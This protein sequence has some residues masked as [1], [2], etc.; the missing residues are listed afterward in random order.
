LGAIVYVGQIIGCQTSSY[1]L[2]RADEKKVL[3]TVLFF[4]ILCLYWFTLVDDFANLV[5]CRAFTGL[6]QESTGVYFP[7]WV[8]TFAS[9]E[10]KS[11]WM[12]VIMIGSTTGNIFGYLVAAVI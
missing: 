3:A 5:V 12:A 10:K 1:L 11:A 9:E 8:D 7:V 4:N 2:Q 6:F